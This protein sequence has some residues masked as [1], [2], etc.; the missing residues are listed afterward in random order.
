MIKKN[1]S[2]GG[3]AG[4]YNDLVSAEGSYQSELILPN[5]KRLLDVKSGERILD[6]AC[7]QGFFSRAW[8]GLGAKVVGTDIAPELIKFAKEKG[9]PN[10]KYFVASADSLGDKVKAGE[11]DKATIVLAL[12]NIENFNG[13]ISEAGRALKVGGSLFVVLN[14]P[15]F[16]IPKK[17][18]WGFD[19]ENKIQY[20]RIDG[21]LGEFNTSIEMHPG[22]KDK[23]ETVSFHRSLQLYFKIF[24]KNGFVV[25]RLEEWNSQKVSQPGPRQKAEDLARKEIP[26]FLCLELKKLLL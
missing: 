13:A 10:E 11:F 7:G 22:Q 23:K 24:N 2:W 5:L 12:Q 16:R 3:V 18:A 21:Y 4:W 15:A 8:A 1:T 20:R 26:L 6:I 25:S 19:E 14:H 17:S 9:G